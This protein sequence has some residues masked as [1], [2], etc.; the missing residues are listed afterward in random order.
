MIE[1][2]VEDVLRGS[3]EEWISFL[4]NQFKLEMGYI[5]KWQHKLV[6]IIQRRNLLVHNGGN[7]NSIYRR[8]VAPELQSCNSK[9]LSTISG[10]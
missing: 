1:Q 10:T 2:R 5:E 8:K 7:I 4:K 6:E 9:N 3:F